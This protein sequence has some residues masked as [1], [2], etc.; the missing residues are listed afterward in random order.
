MNALYRGSSS[1]IQTHFSGK[2]SVSTSKVPSVRGTR[3][4]WAF[5]VSPVFLPAWGKRETA[6]FVC[7]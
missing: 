5:L 7:S 4:K 1:S 3:R 2:C 6:D